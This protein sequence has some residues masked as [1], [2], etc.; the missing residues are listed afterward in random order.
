MQRKGWILIVAI[1]ATVG[2]LA[3]EGQGIGKDVDKHV[4]VCAEGKD[5]FAGRYPSV[6]QM[7]ETA[8]MRCIR[9][10]QTDEALSLIRAGVDIKATNSL[11]ETAL[12][13]AVMTR[14]LGI[15]RALLDTDADVNEVSTGEPLIVVVVKRGYLDMLKLFL[16]KGANVNALDLEEASIL[17][18]A[19]SHGYTK[20]VSL[21][22][23]Q[24]AKIDFDSRGEFSGGPPLVHAV[25]GV[26]MET[27]RLLL[28]RG[29]DVNQLEWYHGKTPL[30]VAVCKGHRRIAILLL[31]SG[32]E[33]NTRDAGSFS[34]KANDGVTPL[35]CAVRNGDVEMV[36]LLIAAGADVNA[37]TWGKTVLGIAKK[38]RDAHIIN[39]LRQAGA[40]E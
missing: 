37:D 35:M 17:A 28:K 16:E 38:E 13:Y 19:A 7:R 20:I 31:E 12:K 2:V 36:K 39:V 9:Y 29:A 34:G 23:D 14:S 10:G 3:F 27:V 24:G 11:G 30:W 22:L 25:S 18:A 1:A 32:A 6:Q 4:D 33:V 15:V 26:Q 21:L 8:L 5:L 40:K